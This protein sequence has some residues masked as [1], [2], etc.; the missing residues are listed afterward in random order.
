[1]LA[2]YLDRLTDTLAQHLQLAR[3][4][5]ERELGNAGKRTQLS[6][7]IRD[8]TA[9]VAQ[10]T[11]DARALKAQVQPSGPGRAWRTR[12]LTSHPHT[13]AFTNVYTQLET[14]LSKLYAPRAIHILSDL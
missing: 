2:R 8:T 10:Q 4:M 13:H 9:A 12:G 14:A 6:E 5:Q 1:M 11:T 7:Q 3:A